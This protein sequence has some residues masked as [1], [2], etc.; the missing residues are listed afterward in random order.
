MRATGALPSEKRVMQ[1]NNAQW[2]WYYL[3]IEKDIEENELNSK[4]KIEYVT[5]FI[6]PKLAKRI[7]DEE[8]VTNKR[9]NK[10]INQIGENIEEEISYG[11]VF[12]NNEFDKQLKEAM[13]E[14]G[15]KEEEFVELP[16]SDGV[17]NEFESRDDFLSRV[18]QN[19]AIIDK[20]K[21]NNTI[22]DE[23]S[24]EDDKINNI[25]NNK[26]IDINDIDDI[27]IN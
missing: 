19:K 5:W 13:K 26:D 2:L 18:L 25:I 16:S 4:K 3:N 24:S 9:Q 17:G 22:V 10:I 21:D 8:N 1:M 11:N 7:S 6:N 27:E 14:A 20:N 23:S 12:T 15:I